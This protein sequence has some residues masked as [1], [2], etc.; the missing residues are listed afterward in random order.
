MYRK[1]V[2]PKTGRLVNITSKL[3]INVLNNY[4]LQIGGNKKVLK[5]T[6]KKPK[7][8]ASKLP[9][10]TTVFSLD[11][12]NGGEIQLEKIEWK[13][14]ATDEEE[15]E[16]VE[17]NYNL[18]DDFEE[19]KK[20]SKNLNKILLSAT[21]GDLIEDLSD[22]ESRGLEGVYILKR[23]LINGKLEVVDLDPFDFWRGEGGVGSGFSLGP[24]YP[25]GYWNKA[26]FKKA[27]WPNPGEDF[28][29][30][31]PV[32]KEIL[33][34]LTAT[35]L[36]ESVLSDEI[37]SSVH[38]NWGTLEFVGEKNEVINKIQNIEFIDD[39]AYFMEHE[40]NQMTARIVNWQ[41]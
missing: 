13:D 28:G 7:K 25:I 37:I 32:N 30:P 19:K 8:K 26:Q 38:F 21:E 11:L 22:E 6:M 39:N 27:Y 36:T 16:W 33:L 40:H 41:W 17:T 35:D 14:G 18:E 2:N 24:K 4:L 23:S 3:G 31:Q 9:K 5:K 34:S 29:M 20:T 1:I 12:T 15:A 10:K